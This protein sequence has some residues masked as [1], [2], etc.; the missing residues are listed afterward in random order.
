LAEA[1]NPD[2]REFTASHVR[3]TLLE[4]PSY[5]PEGHF[6]AMDRDRIV[7]SGLAMYD[8]KR[9]AIK[10]PEAYFD[11]FIL[12]D[13]LGTDLEG[14]LFGRIVERIGQKGGEW[15]VT[16]VDTRYVERV[17][18]LE[19]LGFSK[20]EYENHGM[21]KDPRMVEEPEVPEGYG[22]RVARIPEEL[23]TMHTVLNE[24]FATR[25]KWAP[26]PFEVFR[27]SWIF[28]ESEDRSGIFLASR[29]SDEEVIGMVFSAI[30]RKYN[31][32]H[33]VRRGGTYSL[34][35]IPSERKKGLG[36]CLTLKSLKWIGDKL[37]DVAYVSVNVANKDALNIYQSLGYR[38]IQVYQGYRKTII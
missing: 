17:S 6:I 11:L 35:V 18:L 29:D 22:I 26:K 23:E 13:Y 4:Y 15:I 8:P 9:A 27:K 20:T 32:E 19:K 1:K 36:T 34:A 16:R 24:S 33:G 38:T 7:G 30:N 14:E 21:E 28:D 25:D 5:D 10:G 31:E 37:M 12:P 2:F 3:R